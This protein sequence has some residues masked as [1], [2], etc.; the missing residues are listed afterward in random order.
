M[1]QFVI[2]LLHA[3]EQSSAKYD[4]GAVDF[5][6]KNV[7]FYMTTCCANCVTGPN[8]H[9]TNNVTSS[10]YDSTNIMPIEIV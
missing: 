3:R 5:N 2:G 4:I 6:E 9:I 7:V 1:V 8:T 10:M